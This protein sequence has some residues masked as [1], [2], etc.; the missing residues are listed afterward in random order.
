LEFLDG[1][2]S[3]FR[4]TYL[5]RGDRVSYV[6]LD[7]V[8]T[9][10]VPEDTVH[11][12][13]NVKGG[14]RRKSA[15]RYRGIHA[16]QIAGVEMLEP[17]RANRWNDVPIDEAAVSLLG[18]EADIRD[19]MGLEPSP[20]ELAN[21]LIVPRDIPTVLDGSDPFSQGALSFLLGYALQAFR[22][23][24]PCSVDARRSRVDEPVGITSLGNATGSVWTFVRH[25]LPLR[26]FRI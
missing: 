3:H 10:R 25:H 9:Y 26:I 22:Y 5:R 20:N 23:L 19:R 15:I 17:Q 11:K 16:L 24:P 13:M 2:D 12:A 6:S 14:S 1:E 4:P 18:F 8:P 7:G 21:G